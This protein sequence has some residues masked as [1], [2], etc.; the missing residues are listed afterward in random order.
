MKGKIMYRNGTPMTARMSVADQKLLKML[1][2]HEGV[3]FNKFI[4]EKI[5]DGITRNYDIREWDEYYL[6]NVQPDE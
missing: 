5:N 1:A 4:R 3:S 6:N 2:K